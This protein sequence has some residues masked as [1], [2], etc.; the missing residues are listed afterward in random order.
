MV[1]FRPNEDTKPEDGVIAGLAIRIVL[2]DEFPPEV[3]MGEIVEISA[4]SVT[5]NARIDRENTEKVTIQITSDTK[6]VIMKRGEE[7]QEA[8]LSDFAKGDKVAVDYR[9]G[10]A[11]VIKKVMVPEKK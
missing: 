1:D 10:K 2:I 5:I 4:S 11:L 6:F 7:P 8:K 3:A 9:D